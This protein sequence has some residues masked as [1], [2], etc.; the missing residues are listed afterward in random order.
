MAVAAEID[1]EFFE[2][3]RV[4]IVGVDDLAQGGLG[5]KFQRV[6]GFNFTL[7]A[8]CRRCDF[9][10]LAAVAKGLLSGLTTAVVAGQR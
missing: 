4:A 7:V 6:H 10:R 1:V 2:N 9:M 3:L 8:R 5:A